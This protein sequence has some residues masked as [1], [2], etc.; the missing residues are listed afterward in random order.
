MRRSLAH[1]RTAVS[2][3]VGIGIVVLTLLSVGLLAATVS[4]FLGLQDSRQVVA[5][6]IREDA[7]WAAFQTD[8]EAARLVEAMLTAK[9]TGDS[10]DIAL[11]FD[12]LYSR[13]GLLKSGQYGI[14]LGEQSGVGEIATKV[15]SQVLH[16]ATDIDE[17]GPISDLATN[18]RALDELLE[19]ARAIRTETGKLIVAANAAVNDWRVAGRDASLATFVKIGFAVAGLTLVL[20]LIVG[21]LALQL[22]HISRTGRKMEKL[23][24]RNAKSAHAAEAA[25]RAKS[26]FLAT[27]SHEIRTPLNAIIGMADVLKQSELSGEQATQLGMIR[28]AGDV[29]LDVINDILD[30]SKLE[31]GAV[32][33]ERHATSLPEIID[34]VREIM[35]ARAS[36]ASLEFTMTAPEMSVTVDA[37]RLRQVLLNLVGN[38]IKFTREGAVS[39][40]A[41]LNGELLRIEV[42]DTGRG[43]PEDQFCRLFQ[44][45]SQLDSSSTRA[46]GGT[47]LGL[48]IC[49]R[50]MEA[51]GGTISVTSVVGKGSTFWI[52]MPATPAVALPPRPLA[53]PAAKL[54]IASFAA[55]SSVLVVDDSEVNRLVAAGL[56]KSLGYQVETAE[57]GQLA[58]ERMAEHHYDL[59]LMDMQMPV[60]DGIAATKAIRA[61]GDETPIVGLTANA[62]ETDRA[63]CLA[64]GMNDHLPKP[65]TREKLAQ[66]LTARL[67]V[68]PQSAVQVVPIVADVPR[69]LEI[70]ADQQQALRD[71]LGSELFDQLVESFIRDGLGL[72]DNARDAIERGDMDQYDALLHTLKGAALTLGFAGI[73]QTASRLREKTDSPAD[74]IPVHEAVASLRAAA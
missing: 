14:A 40:T 43:I 67:A 70:N 37:A 36:A 25:N 63:A 66:I 39:V 35:A 9:L 22:R 21:I 52:E 64:A 47:G 48:A 2:R 34:S 19:H 24:E 45:F 6:S 18:A 41:T 17:V 59:V 56:L 32:T 10:K 12:L 38:A 42:S 31:A 5:G 33:I 49:R 65:V 74:L 28:H 58:L 55:S 20:V 13:V 16:L 51:M 8:R 29:L 3:P 7:V 30:Y 4:L 72:V 53:V 61:R 73:G 71:E 46:F 1:T 26:A 44:D 57:N 50:L 62:F 54:P 68:R 27:M 60:M 11:R 15:V 23:S 69:E